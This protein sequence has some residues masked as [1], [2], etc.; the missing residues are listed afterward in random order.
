VTDEWLS[1]PRAYD[2]TP[3]LSADERLN[4]FVERV[5]DYDAEIATVEDH[6][7]AGEIAAAIA[8]RGDRPTL[9]PQS[10]PAEWTPK[11]VRLTFDEG[12]SA[13]V[14]DGFESIITTATLGIAE[15]GSVVLQHVPGQGRRAATLLP[16]FHVCVLRERDLVQSVPEAF[17]RLG[18]D[19]MRPITFISGPSATAD[20]EMT[21][22]RGVHGPRF[23]HVIVVR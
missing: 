15:T 1:V 19:P 20:I 14:L 22:I 5:R 21:R 4:L 9:L 10:F 17:A 16:D 18:E 11:A 2:Q 23:L 6:D 7:V 12:F 13:E 8:A 3:R